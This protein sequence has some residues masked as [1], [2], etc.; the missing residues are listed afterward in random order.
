MTTSR[1]AERAAFDNGSSTRARHCVAPRGY[2][3]IA[4]CGGAAV[5]RPSRTRLRAAAAPSCAKP[6]QAAVPSARTCSAPEAALTATALKFGRR[7]DADARGHGAAECRAVHGGTR[8]A[9]APVVFFPDAERL[10]ARHAQLTTGGERAHFNPS[11]RHVPFRGWGET[12]TR[13]F[14]HALRGWT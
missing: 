12:T 4:R 9:F 13:S 6:R 14:R 1:A 2:A 7:R 5:A 11:A 3:V 10:I 8:R